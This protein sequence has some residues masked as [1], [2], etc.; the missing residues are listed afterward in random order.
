MGIGSRLEL[1]SAKHSKRR[2]DGSAEMSRC[3]V[4][5]CAQERETME[6]AV[7]SKRSLVLGWSQRVIK[8]LRSWEKI[9]WD[10]S[11]V[12]DNTTM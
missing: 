10:R 2:E 9:G 3:S 5:Y 11:R 12:V 1:Q 6:S 7:P 4:N 8:S